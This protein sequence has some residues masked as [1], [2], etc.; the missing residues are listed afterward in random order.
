MKLLTVLGRF[1]RRW[2]EPPPPRGQHGAAL[3]AP[4][5]VPQPPVSGWCCSGPE[6]SPRVGRGQLHPWLGFCLGPRQ[7]EK[8]QAPAWSLQ[9]ATLGVSPSC[10]TVVWGA[11][12]AAPGPH[13][14][15]ASSCTRAVAVL[16]WVPGTMSPA[17]LGTSGFGPAGC[18]YEPEVRRS[19]VLWARV[20]LPVTDEGFYCLN[21]P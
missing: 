9:V 15:P 10:P 16:G 18:W 13:S 3:T 5:R 4:R 20:S 7:N 19:K 1:A 2:P 8:S 11:A 12:P 14:A 21:L 6:L 17:G